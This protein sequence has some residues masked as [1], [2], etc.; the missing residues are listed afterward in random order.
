MNQNIMARFRLQK[1]IELKTL[2]DTACGNLSY[3]CVL[4]LIK[5]GAL[6]VKGRKQRTGLKKTSI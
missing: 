1:Y 3:S 2:I 4:R 6:Y 5:D